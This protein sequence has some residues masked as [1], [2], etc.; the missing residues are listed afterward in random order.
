MDQYFGFIF[1]FACI[2]ASTLAQ[3]DS[4]NSSAVI[5]CPTGPD[6]SSYDFNLHLISLFVVLV[7]SS[8]GALIPVIAKRLP[9]LRTPY[10]VFIIVKHFGTGVI[11]A[12]AF[13]YDAWPGLIAMNAAVFIFFIEYAAVNFV[14]SNNLKSGNFTANNNETPNDHSENQN[15]EVYGGSTLLSSDAQIIGI[16]ILEIGICF[17]SVIIGMNL[18]VSTGSNFISLWVA[19]VF[20]QMFEGL[21]LG[22]R[23]AELN[24]PENSIKPWLMSCAYGVTTPIGIA[25]GLGVHKSYNPASQTALIVQGT[26]DSLS[27]GILIY[28]ALVELMANDFIYDP[29][30]RKSSKIKQLG[31]F[32]CLLFGISF[33][34]LIGM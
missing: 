17:H 5:S 16:L 9:Q 10:A 7:T 12:T 28:T 11:L 1:V 33:M 24:Y 30:F 31:A 15:L 27:A 25:M 13:D 2:V 20:H 32:I 6:L 14:D 3:D 21:G 29:Q 4:S 26:L 18:S 23:I 8:S 22:S 34:V 19:L